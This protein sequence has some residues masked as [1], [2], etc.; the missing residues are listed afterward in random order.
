MTCAHSVRVWLL[1][2]LLF[3]APMASAEVVIDWV[4]VG[5]AGN[6]ADTTGYGSVAEPYRISR[7]EVTNAQYTEFLNAVAV[8][9]TRALYNT[10]M[11][12]VSYPDR[13]G[14]TRSGSPGSFS[15]STIAG[16]EDMPVNYVSFWDAARFANWLH[17]GQPTG[18]QG[19]AATEAGGY[20]L[21]PTDIANNT[22][23]RTAAAE[24]FVPSEDEWYKA[25]YYD[26]STMTY[27]DYP[28]GSDT[29]M[30]CSAPGATTNTANCG[31]VWADMTDVG[32]YTGAA[33]PDG[34]FD[35]LG[36][37]WEW[38]EAIS[39]LDRG[40][41]GGYFSNDPNFLS[42][43]SR[44]QE[45]ASD[46]FFYL[47]F[48][49]A[50]PVP[51][52]TIDWVI[53]D[54]PGNA[55]D[56]QSQGCF[57]SVTERYRIS[58]FEVTNAQYTVFLNAV[59]ATDSNALYNTNM[60]SG[61]GG[62]A[63]SG[64]AGSFSYIAI[65]GREDMPVNWVS[66]WDVTRFA[67]WLHNGQP[68]GAQGNAT[69]EAGAYTLTPTGIANNTVTRT[70]GA[71][72]FIASED[73]WYKAAYYDPGAMTYFDYPVSSDTQ[74]CTVPWAGA[75][76]ANCNDAVADLTSVGS[77]T[78]AASPSGT[79]DQ[80]GNVW[81]W[82][83]A[84]ISGS[85]R[86]LRAGSF[87]NSASVLAASNQFFENPTLEIAFVGF[88]VAS[89]IPEV[90]IDWVTVGETGNTC[91]TQSQ[92][93]FGSVAEQ[94]R[95]SKFEVT[96]AQYTVFLN[97]VAA[98]ADT[99]GLYNT[100]MDFMGIWRSGSSGSL[101]YNAIVG[102]ED[103]PVTWVSFW[104]AIRFANWLHNGQP[105]GEQDNTTTEDGAYTLTPTGLINNTVTR[106]A[107]AKVFVPSEDEWYKAAYYE[108]G[109]MYYWSYPMIKAGS[110][111]CSYSASPESGYANCESSYGGLTD[112]GSFT[113]TP[114]PGGTFDQGGNVW[115][116][117]EAISGLDRGRRGGS[118]L[119]DYFWLLAQKRGESVAFAEED[120]LG[121]RV[122]SLVPAPAVPS[123][124]PL[125]IATL[126]SL[127]GLA[128]WRRLRA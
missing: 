113:G 81:E 6:A 102:G 112:V 87:N 122:A 45:G 44:S 10:S 4:T 55:C 13:G 104:D 39:G 79:F 101:T 128:G 109:A 15:Y 100:N 107:G 43:S 72:V 42:A 3:L 108:A 66:F 56:T 46:E 89:P 9:D 64:S 1:L 2:G 62:I 98:T 8:T 97:A 57:G 106:N 14:I 105:L 27:F 73:E 92:G 80:G 17:N 30:T 31:D 71:E 36:N 12:V 86:G 24:V 69:T 68:A 125:G 20:E 103:K 50:S 35:Q 7:F 116:W 91:Q 22:V 124:S 78:G 16:R 74:T 61:F 59:A 70:V 99:H 37:V 28:A 53:L 40:R 121:F 126:L 18:A 63:R 67:N 77:Y 23:T 82:N 60:G 26:A 88:R 93:C 48:R 83:E 5:D 29:V 114:S 11:A 34:T 85:N 58:K 76:S 84:V 111:V 96:N 19:Y 38:N 32:S 94:Y 41:R 120:S 127:L 90:T 115:E 95:I 118:F 117:N 33:S 52:V 119:S 21:A 75:N 51:E 49:V 123:L 65:A 47:G 54:D 25:A 110:I